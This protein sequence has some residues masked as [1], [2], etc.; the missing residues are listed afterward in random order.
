[1]TNKTITAGTGEVVTRILADFLSA[2]IY[3]CTPADAEIRPVILPVPEKLQT[4][5]PVAGNTARATPFVPDLRLRSQ[6]GA[7]LLPFGQGERPENVQTEA[8]LWGT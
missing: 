6:A 7:G 1:M 8:A 4:T 5:A 2:I 3:H